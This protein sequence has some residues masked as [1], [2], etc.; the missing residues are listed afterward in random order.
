MCL[1]QCLCVYVCSLRSRW[2]IVTFWR[3]VYNYFGGLVLPTFDRFAHK[4]II[5]SVIFLGLH[6]YIH[7]PNRL[8]FYQNL[9]LKNTRQRMVVGDGPEENFHWSFCRGFHRVDN[10]RGKYYPTKNNVQ[11]SFITQYVSFRKLSLVF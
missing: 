1:C 8:C 3:K 7:V 5:C 2:P 11:K 6:S 10:W 4:L 9:H